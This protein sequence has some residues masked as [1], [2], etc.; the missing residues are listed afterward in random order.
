MDTQDTYALNKYFAIRLPFNKRREIVWREIIRYLTPYIPKD[1]A[2]AELGAGYCHLINNVKAK[3]RYALDIAPVIE[4][5]AAEG[6]QTIVGSSEDL[7]RI[8]DHTLDVVFASN[9]FEHLTDDMYGRTL[10]AVKRALK[11]GGRLIILQPNFKYAYREYF[12]DYTHIRIFTHLGLSDSLTAAGFSVEKV[13]PRFVPYSVSAVPMPV[14]SW[15][16]RLYLRSPWKPLARQM[17]LIARS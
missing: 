4:E 6:V 13:W 1:G 12:D 14:P 5:H 17:L 10:L 7:S 16:I 2:V 8:P 15:I 3:T 9:L 11:P